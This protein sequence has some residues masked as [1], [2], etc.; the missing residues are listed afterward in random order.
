MGIEWDSSL[1]FLI[2]NF[3]SSTFV[4][5]WCPCDGLCC[6]QKEW[7]TFCLYCLQA[8]KD[9]DMTFW[10]HLKYLDILTSNLAISATFSIVM[11][12]MF[13]NVPKVTLFIP[14]P[15]VVFMPLTRGFEEYHL[16]LQ[17]EQDLSYQPGCIYLCSY[18]LHLHFANLPSDVCV[19][20]HYH[21]RLQQSYRVNRVVCCITKPHIY[22]GIRLASI[23]THCFLPYW[24]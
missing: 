5:S 4:I 13:F 20:K 23:Y 8:V 18:V 10:R 2:S 22:H 19:R 3:L 15:W 24:L 7:F 6:R 16:L 21:V 9:F 17:A 11:F 12:S 1:L 14:F